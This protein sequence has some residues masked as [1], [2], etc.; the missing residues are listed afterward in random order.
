MK[1]QYL[2]TTEMQ[3]LESHAFENYPITLEEMMQNAGKAIFEVVT[4]EVFAPFCYPEQVCH[5][6]SEAES[7]D[8]KVLVIAGKGNNGG[9]ALVTARLLHEK[10]IAVTVLSPYPDGEF[11]EMAGQELKKVR[12]AGIKVVENFDSLFSGVDVEN[13]DTLA[14]SDHHKIS[15]TSSDERPDLSSYSLIIDALFGFSLTGNP[16]PP[17]DRIID[18][19]NTADI[20]VLAVDVPSGLDVHTGSLGDPTVKANYTVALGML[21]KG[22]KEHPDHIGKVYIGDL[23]IPEQT[24][25]DMG[26][27]MPPFEFSPQT[28]IIHG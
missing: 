1:N 26:F 6:R 27:E 14:S 4:E 8:L 10:G 5:E 16:R 12:A 18:Q 13:L 20:P 11:T 9:D 28:S 3:A 22:F 7:K 24:Y 23:G 21:K 17:A 2:N 15:G 25:R 19:I